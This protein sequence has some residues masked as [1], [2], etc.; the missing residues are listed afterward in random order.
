M[1][2]ASGLQ[3]RVALQ[4]PAAGTEMLP[5]DEVR[6]RLGVLRQAPV[7]DLIGMTEADARAELEAR[8]LVLEVIGDTEVDE[9][10]GLDG[11]IATQ[12]QLA[13]I[14][15]PDGTTIRVTLG[16]L[17]PPTA[18]INHHDDHHHDRTAV[19]PPS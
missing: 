13:G 3:G 7:P 17:P 14:S 2:A 9:E 6:I 19:V 8:G 15:V 18:T 12:D 11:L 1:T 5:N 16:V 4:E 10:S